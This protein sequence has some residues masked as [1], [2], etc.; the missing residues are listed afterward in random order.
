M[1]LIIDISEDVYN[2]IKDGFYGDN[3]RRMAIA[4][5]NG[6]P[7]DDIKAEIQDIYVGYRYGYEVMADVLAILDKHIGKENE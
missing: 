1:K 7:L 2:D 5:G 3:Q 4:I 6:T